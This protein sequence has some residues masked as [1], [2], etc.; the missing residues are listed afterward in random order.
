MI[1][2]LVFTDRAVRG[3]PRRPSG[4]SRSV[5]AGCTAPA[6]GWC[7]PRGPASS[8]AG[9]GGPRQRWSGPSWRGA[10]RWIMS[11]WYLRAKKESCFLLH[12]HFAHLF[13]V[14][15]VVVYCKAC[16]LFSSSVRFMGSS[17]FWELTAAFLEIWECVWHNIVN[18][19]TV[20]FLKIFR[21]IFL[22]N[23]FSRFL[24]I[25]HVSERNV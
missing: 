10:W 3:C 14:N 12:R 23:I 8:A 5:V 9:T 16:S 15:I 6:R 11:F 4:G 24:K 20:N 17:V 21:D 13:G 22:L 2:Y 19:T 1:H 7:S 25:N 18:S